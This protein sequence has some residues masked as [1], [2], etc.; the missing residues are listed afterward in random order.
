MFGEKLAEQ[1]AQRKAEF[2]AALYRRY[3]L[4]RQL[5]D[6]DKN[7]LRMEAGLAELDQVKRNWEAQEAIEK[8]QA[9]K[10]K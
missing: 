10:D 3:V 9:D 6:L 1:F 8:A 2:E 7:I 5:D 4:G